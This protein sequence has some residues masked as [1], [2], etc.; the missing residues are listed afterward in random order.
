MARRAKTT[1]PEFDKTPDPIRLVQRFL[2]T[3]ISPKF[4]LIEMLDHAI[5]VH[6]SG[7]SDETRSLIEW[8]AE[9]GELRLITATTIAQGI[10]FPVSSIFL[11][12]TNWPYGDL[13]FRN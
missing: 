2:A 12:T 10:N 9:D 7:L 6:H 13:G 1:L 3:E 11:S 4:E 8:L 5:G